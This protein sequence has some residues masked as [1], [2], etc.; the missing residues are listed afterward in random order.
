MGQGGDLSIGVELTEPQFGVDQR[1]ELVRRGCGRI[2]RNQV[3]HQPNPVVSDRG[4]AGDPAYL[5]ECRHVV[6]SRPDPDLVGVARVSPLTAGGVVALAPEGDGI[7]AH[8]ARHPWAVDR[9][10]Q[11]L[12]A[13]DEAAW[14]TGIASLAE[15]VPVADATVPTDR[16]AAVAAMTKLIHDRE[17][18]AKEATTW[19]DRGA[20]F[21]E[22]VATCADC[23]TETRPPVAPK[24]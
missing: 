13:A 12:F 16:E 18:A 24:R 14:N 6:G 22:L 21:G 11:G 7:V 10:W 20:L 5:A 2:N 4:Q 3:G 1:L 9:L 8:M 19:G 15:D 23:H 17:A